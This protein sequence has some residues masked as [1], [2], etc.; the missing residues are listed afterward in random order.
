[1]IKKELS[2]CMDHTNSINQ[3]FRS[4]ADIEKLIFRIIFLT[5]R[6]KALPVKVTLRCSL[7]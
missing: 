5:N 2:I 4:L 7:K 3:K 1:M 6:F